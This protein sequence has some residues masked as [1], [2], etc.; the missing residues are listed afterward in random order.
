MH[1]YTHTYTHAHA[2]TRT[3]VTQPVPFFRQPSLSPV[4]AVAAGAH[5]CMALLQDGTVYSWGNNRAG[6]LGQGILGV[7]FRPLVPGDSSVVIDALVPGGALQRT[8]QVLVGC[9]W[10]TQHTHAYAHARMHAHGRSHARTLARSH[11][12]CTH[13]LSHTVE[14]MIWACVC[15]Y[16]HTPPTGPNRC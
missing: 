13:T 7:R 9:I 12:L 8:E 5:F 11:K 4:A 10:Y 15:M 2:H 3:Q 1:T 6:Q 14:Y 16:M